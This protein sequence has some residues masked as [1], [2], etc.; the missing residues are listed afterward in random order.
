[1]GNSFLLLTVTKYWVFRGVVLGGPSSKIE[2]GAGFE[3]LSS[4]AARIRGPFPFSTR[5]K[6]VF[7][8]QTEK[9]AILVLMIDRPPNFGKTHLWAFGASRRPEGV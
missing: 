4:G 5:N 7:T 6:K 3:Q 9:T 2:K 1:M 8:L